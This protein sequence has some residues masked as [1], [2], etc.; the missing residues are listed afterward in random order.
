[1]A[2]NSINCQ[3]L[4]QTDKNLEQKTKK[5]EKRIKQK[6]GKCTNIVEIVC[7]KNQQLFNHVIETT[8]KQK[9]QNKNQQG[10]AFHWLR[11]C[12]Q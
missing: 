8:S 6:K 11:Y 5:E 2:M 12:K 7:L 10:T 9:T 4:Q 3:K 1:M